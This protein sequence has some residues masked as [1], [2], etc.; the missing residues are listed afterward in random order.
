MMKNTHKLGSKGTLPGFTLIELL[1]VIAIIAILAAMLLPALASAK[2]K[3][4]M[5]GCMSND[6]QT[7]L[8]VQMF[9]DDNSDWLPPSPANAPAGASGGGPTFG[10]SSSG[11][12][13]GLYNGQVYGYNNT[14][15]SE[16][17]YYLTSYLG[18]PSPDTTMRLAPVM[19]CPGFNANITGSTPTNTVV[20]YLD[21]THSDDGSATNN[22]FPFGYPEAV[23]GYTTAELQPCKM[24]KVQATAAAPSKI[25][26][27]SD[28]DHVAVSDSAWDSTILPAKPVHGSVRVHL[29]FDGHVASVKVNPAGGLDAPH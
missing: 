2:R 28:V 27:L 8:A 17:V 5:A 16:L 22:F 12:P 11:S 24:S 14:S 15:S 6:R 1:V 4:T 23:S 19:L 10:A 25:W 29:Y 21:G 13:Y 7:H 26:Y 20:Y 9:C 3:A 18:Y